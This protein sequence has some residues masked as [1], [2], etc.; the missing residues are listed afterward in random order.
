MALKGKIRNL[1]PAQFLVG[2]VDQALKYRHV[3][4]LRSVK[5]M[6]EVKRADLNH[7]FSDDVSPE[8]SSGRYGN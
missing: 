3:E 2:P 5:G 4:S 7:R 8:F 6:P 1:T